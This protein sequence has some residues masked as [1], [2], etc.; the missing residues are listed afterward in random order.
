MLSGQPHAPA[1][2]PAG[3]KPRVP[4]TRRPTG[5]QSWSGS[6][7]EDK[8]LFPPARIQLVAHHFTDVLIPAPSWTT[9]NKTIVTTT[10]VDLGIPTFIDVRRVISEMGD[11]AWP[12]LIQCAHGTYTASRQRNISVSIWSASILAFLNIFCE[13]QPGAKLWEPLGRWT[14]SSDAQTQTSCTTQRAALGSGSHW[15]KN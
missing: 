14:R 7:E 11:A 2:F 6:L 10:N 13:T 3:R 1:L 12:P 5:P 15:Q 9:T 8:N 4:T